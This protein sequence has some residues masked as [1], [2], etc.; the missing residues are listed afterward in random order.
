MRHWVPF[1]CPLSTLKK[2]R[3]MRADEIQRPLGLSTVVTAVSPSTIGVATKKVSKGAPAARIFADVKFEHCAWSKEAY[4]GWVVDE[5]LEGDVVRGDF[6]FEVRL[7][8]VCTA[9]DERL[10]RRVLVDRVV[11]REV[12]VDEEVGLVVRREGNVDGAIV[13]AEVDLGEGEGAQVRDRFVVRDRAFGGAC[14][15]LGSVIGEKWYEGNNGHAE[16]GPW[17]GLGQQQQQQ[18]GWWSETSFVSQG[19]FRASKLWR[20]IPGQRN[21]SGVDISTYAWS[22]SGTVS[23]PADPKS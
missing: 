6:E 20:K 10:H 7:G 21:V 5:R 15:D 9:R 16:M 17:P 22:R 2:P 18:R 8:V 19:S 4:F 13:V 3:G 14:W 23:D 11:R 12:G 1:A